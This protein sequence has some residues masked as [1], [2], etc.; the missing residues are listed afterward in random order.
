[1]DN[2]IMAIT[3][4]IAKN[5]N[6]WMAS[7]PSLD[8]IKKVSAR[9]GVGFGT[10]QRVKN[11]DG[12]PTVNNLADIAKAFGKKL[13]DILAANSDELSKYPEISAQRFSIKEKPT[14]QE[15]QQ[16]IVS[17]LSDMDIDDQ[18]VWLAT[19]TAAA[20]KARR[21]K[22]VERDGKDHEQTTRD[23][24]KVKRHVA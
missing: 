13:E 16:E 11:G 5:L 20:N 17:Q 22:Q 2:P 8:T 18:N 24:P 23:P 10:V 15:L 19:I 3:D 21:S 7:S 6:S 1:M 14:Q 12:N 9:S 4:N